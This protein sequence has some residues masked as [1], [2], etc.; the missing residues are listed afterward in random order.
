MRKR[1]VSSESTEAPLASDMIS[2]KMDQKTRT[3]SDLSMF[4]KLAFTEDLRSSLSDHLSCV[5]ERA[6]IAYW[7]NVLSQTEIVTLEH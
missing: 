1:H 7:S 5:A 6:L 3:R 2:R 4:L